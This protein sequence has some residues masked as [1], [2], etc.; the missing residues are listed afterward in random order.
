MFFLSFSYGC[1]DDVMGTNHT[2]GENGT[3]F[4]IHG[5]SENDSSAVNGLCESGGDCLHIFLIPAIC[6][7]GIIGNIVSFKVF[8]FT[9]FGRRSSGIFLAALSLSDTGFLLAL[10]FSW[11]GNGQL[12]VY[13]KYSLIYCHFIVYTP[14]VCSFLSVWCIVLLMVERFVVVCYPL[15]LH[16]WCSRRRSFT[17]VIVMVIFSLSFYS[18]TFCTSEIRNNEC[19]ISPD[20]IHIAIVFTYIDT[21]VTF[22]F[23][24][25]VVL[26]LNIIVIISIRRFRKRQ[27]LMTCFHD[28]KIK[29]SPGRLLSTAEIRITRML[30]VVSSVFI[31][32][33]LPSHAIRMYIMIFGIDLQYGQG[34]IQ[35]IQLLSNL[36][37]FCNFA[38]NFLLYSSTS[39]I[40]RKFLCL[41][42][43][44]NVSSSTKNAKQPKRCLAHTR[45][46]ANYKVLYIRKSSN[47]S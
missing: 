16:I 45:Y 15:K 38:V 21:V 13:F 5:E 27:V 33:N 32:T 24:I 17:T 35:Q 41:R 12:G 9:S 30:I 23:P 42:T 44:R 26:I 10:F 37:Y 34:I 20:Y 14:Y 28:D 1:L 39:K 8:V 7:F 25:F 43:N 40:F 19:S 31:V 36:L 22:I 18:H 11:L 29:R 46:H 47:M 2:S 4:A 3:M 6:I